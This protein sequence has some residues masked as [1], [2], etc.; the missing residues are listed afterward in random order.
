MTMLLRLRL[1]GDVVMC[2]ILVFMKKVMYLN[3]S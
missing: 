3:L 2:E 1:F